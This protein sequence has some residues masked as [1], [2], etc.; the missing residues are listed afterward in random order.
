MIV[1]PLP[2]MASMTITE[3]QKLC[4]DMKVQLAYHKGRRSTANAVLLSHF[5]GIWSTMPSRCSGGASG[6]RRRVRFAIAS[7]DMKSHE[8]VDSA[9]RPRSRSPPP[10]RDTM[11]MSMEELAEDS[12]VTVEPDDDVIEEHP[13]PLLDAWN[14]VSPPHHPQDVG[15]AKVPHRPKTQQRGKN[16]AHHRPKRPPPK[17][18]SPSKHAKG[19]GNII[20]RLQ[21]NPCR[22][23]FSDNADED[24]T[25]REGSNTAETLELLQQSLSGFHAA[26]VRNVLGSD[27]NTHR[28]RLRI[29][30]QE[31]EET[32]IEES[33]PNMV[34]DHAPFPNYSNQL[35]L[36]NNTH[37][38]GRSAQLPSLAGRGPRPPTRRGDGH[39]ATSYMSLSSHNERNAPLGHQRLTL[40]I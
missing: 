6:S 22:A 31:R 7:E 16:A 12:I 36:H 26:A 1:E 20:H 24:T 15:Q 4:W 40:N 18:P 8:S 13:S 29:D 2:E 30:S 32:Y 11:M 9:L 28:W 38:T 5:N 27:T 23:L 3:L 17:N 25:E 19:R 33:E 37:H 14:A 39:N 10:Q 35:Q 34:G 21:P